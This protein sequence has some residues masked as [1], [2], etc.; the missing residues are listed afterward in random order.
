MVSTWDLRTP[1]RLGIR[2]MDSIS[3]EVSEL[4]LLST[5]LLSSR[6]CCRCPCKALSDTVSSCSPQF[7]GYS[8]MLTPVHCLYSCTEDLIPAK[9]DFLPFAGLPIMADCTQVPSRAFIRTGNPT[10]G[11]LT[12]HSFSAATLETPGAEIIAGGR[13]QQGLGQPPRSGSAVPSH[14]AAAQGQWPGCA[15]PKSFAEP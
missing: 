10:P 4:P 2:S 11:R 14:S 9:D 7:Y 15:F 3:I 5:R 13:G 8:R 1:G 6:A 12:C